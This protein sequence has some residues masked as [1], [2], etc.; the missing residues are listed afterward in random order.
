MKKI[1]YIFFFLCF[2]GIHPSFAQ[3]QTRA[4][5]SGK[6]A[7]IRAMEA[8]AL[9][10][11]TQAKE[12][13]L[14]AYNELG[15]TSG[16]SFA[17]ADTYIMLE[18]LP[19]AALYGKQAVSLEPTNK[20]Y[21]FKLAQIYR[22]AGQ[23]QATLDEL[24]KLL[25]YHPFD[26]DALFMLADTYKDYGEYLKSNQVLNRA[27][28]L[29]GPNRSIYL[30]KFQNF[31]ALSARDSMLVQLESL[32]KL[33]PDDLNTL[34]L[35]SEFYTT[36]GKNDQAKDV[37]ADAL[38]RNSRDPQSL[39]NLAAIYIDGEKWDS[40]GT[41]I[42]NFVSDKLIT[43]EEK[44][45]V[46]QYLYARQ[47]EEPNNVQLRIES[48]RIL[49]L[50]CESEPDYG[51]AFTL[52]GQFYSQNN[53]I[54]NA[55]LKL[56]KGNELLPQ[57]DIAWRLRLQ[58]LL[59]QQKLDE[60][61]EVGQKADQAVPEDAFIQF[62][63]GS[64]HLLKNENKLA[65][66]WLQKASRSPSRRPFK[67][68][69]YSTLGDAY[70]NLKNYEES[71]RVYELALRYDPENHTAMNNYAYNLSIREEQLDR[72]KE[73]ALKA[74]ELEPDNAAYLDTIGW[75]YFQLADYERARRYIKASIDTGSSSAEVLEHLGDVYEKLDNLAEAKK[76]WKQAFDMDSTRTHLKA[77]TEP[78]SQ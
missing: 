71:D 51:L 76:W 47:Q 57:D 3:V 72:A 6:S 11:Y 77:K 55:L 62:F 49:D 10:D 52:A 67:S 8:F 20:W 2:T 54:E 39:I 74:I 38:S 4:E 35:L 32:R 64:A 25:E 42:G 5:L 7:Y 66:E 63:I 24:I 17:L 31:E 44:L 18:D 33:D 37:L 69:I 23:N 40:A 53:D 70:G 43:P 26:Y 13:L 28:E 45:Q 19:N 48:G 50:F 9:E 21:R 41:L 59:N 36:S 58:L 75:V 29:M 68:V 73:L 14:T 30:L 12:L 34:N 60:T 61:I 78:D 15:A 46:A 56:E 22:S 65:V 16:I 1:L 27:L